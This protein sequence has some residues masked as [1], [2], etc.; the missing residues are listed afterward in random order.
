MP[1]EIIEHTADIG[2]R[3]RAGDLPVLFGDAARGFFELVTDPV[4]LKKS[5]P[6][7]FQNVEVNFREENAEE[8]FMHWL[9][10]LLFIFSVRRV[11]LTDCHFDSLTPMMLKL[12][13]RAVLF[14]PKRHVARHE[15]K[16]V[17]H[18]RFRVAWNARG[19][20]AEVY[21]DI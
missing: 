10:E 9:Q 8:L 17:T 13:A 19:W 3:V 14:D 16:A 18:H 5:E 11:V 15:I 20:E 1:Y 21:F 7:V 4:A 12:K 6:V 2:L